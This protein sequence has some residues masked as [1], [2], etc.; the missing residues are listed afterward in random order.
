MNGMKKFF[1]FLLLFA[2]AGLSAQTEEVFT[3]AEQMPAFPG[4]FSEYLQKNIKYPHAEKEAGIDGTVYIT[5]I[6]EKDG[7]ISNVHAV[8]EVPGG[9][10]L[11][12][13]AVRVI[14]RMPNWT[15]GQMNGKPVRVTITQPVKFVLEPD[16]T[17]RCTLACG[18]YISPDSMG[19]VMTAAGPEKPRFP[20]GDTAMNEFFAA[21]FTAAPGYMTNVEGRVWIEFI[22]DTLGAIRN[23]SIYGVYEG[24]AGLANAAA[25][26]ICSMPAWSPGVFKG[27]KKNMKIT[28]QIVYGK[29]G[30]EMKYTS[31]TPKR[32]GPPMPPPPPPPPNPRGR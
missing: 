20:G 16:D 5:F 9:P 19:G 23:V 29:S 2:T 1:V 17:P 30:T 10:G 27:Q 7:S 31:I 14:A 22:V 26:A 24:P 12:K 8:K 6:V 11:T 28:V 3:F 15:P 13:E 4:K 21:K 25:N 32:N 18:T